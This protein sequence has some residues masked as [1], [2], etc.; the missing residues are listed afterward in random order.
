MLI[1]INRESFKINPQS[2]QTTSVVQGVK[3]RERVVVEHKDGCAIRSEYV[4]SFNAGDWLLRRSEVIYP[5]QFGRLPPEC[6]DEET[7]TEFCQVHHSPR[8]LFLFEYDYP[9]HTC[10]NCSETS[11]ID[12]WDHDVD[13]NSGSHFYRCPHC[14]EELGE[15]VEFENP[16]DVGVELGVR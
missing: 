2:G 5:S 11:A 13:A 1:R 9:Q 8:P 16:I 6:D 12:T 15:D 4:F 7:T 14:D 10:G 3:S